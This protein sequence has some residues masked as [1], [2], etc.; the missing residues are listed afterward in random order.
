MNQESLKRIENRINAFLANSSVEIIFLVWFIFIF[1]LFALARP[2]FLDFAL[3]FRKG[4][5]LDELFLGPI[6]FGASMSI[7]GASLFL[8]FHSMFQKKTIETMQ[9][10]VSVVVFSV[11]LF[12]SYAIFSLFLKFIFVAVDPDKVLIATKYISSLDRWLF[13]GYPVLVLREWFSGGFVEWFLVSSYQGL[14]SLLSVVSAILFFC[15]PRMFRTFILSFILSGFICIPFWVS[16]PILSPQIVYDDKY[17]TG[18]EFTLVRTELSQIQPSPYLQHNLQALSRLWVDPSRIYLAVSNFSSVHATYG[19]FIVLAMW[20]L[21]PLFGGLVLLWYVGMLIGAVYL[22]QHFTIDMIAG[23]T[24]G[25]VV[26]L[27]VSWI[28]RKEDGFL[29]DRYGILSLYRAIEHF[30]VQISRETSRW[31]REK[32]RLKW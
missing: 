30:G 6:F 27:C 15:K 26:W 4:F 2:D 7:F 16:V 29:R 23:I 21:R 25:F 3:Y 1:V 5:P 13:Q 24:V 22:G 18:A 9:T 8:F 28:L 10:A 32:V 31:L 17:I 11:F 20:S 12:V 19:L 14:S